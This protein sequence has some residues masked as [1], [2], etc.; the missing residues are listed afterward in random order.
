MPKT[1]FRT[2]A[3]LLELFVAVVSIQYLGT[4]RS[5]RASVSWLPGACA[6]GAPL[7]EAPDANDAMN[8]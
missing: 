5:A 8:T 7:Q 4:I 3:L 6:T 1:S 2:L